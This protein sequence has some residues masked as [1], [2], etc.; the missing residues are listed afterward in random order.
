[1]GAPFVVVMAGGSGTRFW[2]KS[3]SKRPKQL[4]SFG[5]GGGSGTSLL[6]STLS[7]FAGISPVDQQIIVTTELLRDAVQADV[8]PG[9][10]ILAEPQGRNTAP[11]VYWAARAIAARDPRGIMLVMPADHYVPNLDAFRTT[12]AAAVDWAL[13]HDDLVTLGIRPSR[14]ETGYGYLR[15]GTVLAN[16]CRKIDAFVEKPGFEKAKEFLAAGNYLWNGG[17]FV[18][19]VDVILAAFDQHMP[20]MKTAWEQNGSDAL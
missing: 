20:E 17:M 15:T 7:R 19:R 10:Q 12:V 8:A 18:W 9:V 11:C 3:T 5:G 14:P 2:P 1:M 16:G 4:L 13:K 6:A